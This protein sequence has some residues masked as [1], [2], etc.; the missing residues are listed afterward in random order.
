M[1][2]RPPRNLKVIGKT[3]D[4]VTLAWDPP[5]LDGGAAVF[6]HEVS[7]S[8]HKVVRKDKYSKDDVTTPAEP[9]LTSRWCAA[10]PVAANGFT[11]TELEANM[12]LVDISVRCQ[13]AVGWSDPSE[14]LPEVFT[15]DPVP[16]NP[17]LFFRVDLVKANRAVLRWMAPLFKGGVEVTEY[18]VA[19]VDVVPKDQQAVTTRKVEEDRHHEMRTPAIMGEE[20]KGEQVLVLR[21]LRAATLHKDISLRAIGES[22]MASAAVFAPVFTTLPPGQR[23]RIT[24]EL[25]RARAATGGWIDTDFYKDFMQARENREDYISKLERDLGSL[26]AGSADNEDSDEESASSQVRTIHSSQREPIP[27]RMVARTE[28]E[29]LRQQEDLL[30]SVFNGYKRRK[31]QF[32][33][34]LKRLREQIEECE[35]TRLAHIGHRAVL[36]QQLISTQ[37]RVMEIQAELDRV[38]TFKGGHINSSVLHGSQQRF[39]I[40]VL[41]QKLRIELGLGQSSIAQDKADLMEGTKTIAAF[42]VFTKN[43]EKAKKLSRNLQASKGDES[44][45]EKV[46][47]ALASAIKAIQ[48]ER[49]TILNALVRMRM[50]LIIAAFVKWRTGKHIAVDKP[51]DSTKYVIRGI[52]GRHLL[53][54]E[55]GRELM[56]KE[57]QVVMRDAATLRRGFTRMS[58][59]NSQKKELEGSSLFHETELGSFIDESEAAGLD[60]A[61]IAQGD[62][63]LKVRQAMKASACYSRQIDTLGMQSDRI[64]LSA[65]GL[66]H[67][68]LGKAQRAS[69][70]LDIAAVSFDRALELS[71]AGKHLPGVVDALEGL[72]GC[73]LEYCQYRDAISLFKRALARNVEIKDLPRDARLFRLLEEG[74]RRMVDMEQAAVYAQRAEAIE[75]ELEMKLSRAKTSLED[76]TTRL[77]GRTA[78][79]GKVVHLERV[80]AGYVAMCTRR[81]FLVENLKETLEAKKAQAKVLKVQEMKLLLIKEQLREAQET[82]KDAMSSTLIVEGEMMSFEIEELKTRLREREIEV[83]SEVTRHSGLLTA[84]TNRATNAVDELEGLEQDIAI[85][86][87]PLMTSVVGKARLRL[88]GMNS[89]NTAGNEVEGT[90]TGGVEKIIAAEGKKV[91]VYGI[92]RGNLEHVFSGDEP[93]R[94]TGELLGH[95][96]VI[97]ALFFHKNI[98]YTGSM[99]CTVQVWDVDEKKRVL[100]LKGHEATVCSVAADELKIVSGAADKNIHIWKHGDG[101]ILRVLHGHTKSAV[102]LHVG[103]S[104]ILSGG[105][106]GDIRLWG[107]GNS[108]KFTKASENRANVD[109]EE[110]LGRYECKRRLAGH[111][112]SAT[113]VSYGR[114]ELVSGHEDGTVVVWWASTGLI[115]MKS[116]VHGGPVQQLQFDATKVVSCSTDGTITVTDLTTGECTMTLRGH[117]GIVLAVAFDRS[118]IISASDDGTL[119]TWVWATRGPKQDK[120]AVLGPGENLGRLAKQNNT[121]VADIAKWNGVRDTRQLGVGVRLIVAKGNPNEPTEAETKAAEE[122]ALK[123]RRSKT[124]EKARKRVV[125]SGAAESGQQRLRGTL[126]ASDDPS[127]LIRRIARRDAS[128]ADMWQEARSDGDGGSGSQLDS[129]EEDD[130]SHDEER[131][132]EDVLA[133][134]AKERELAAGDVAGAVLGATVRLI[135]KEV[136]RD[137]IASAAPSKGIVGRLNAYCSLNAAVIPAENAHEAKEEQKE[138]KAKAPV[139]KAKYATRKDELGEP[140]VHLPPIEQTRVCTQ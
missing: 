19:Y 93:G 134:Q 17:P 128:F 44:V 109:D 65:L 91:L 57:L 112:R 86:G 12:H 98:V 67:A 55:E 70:R 48:Q 88:I 9:V 14:I 71:T 42:A 80:T 10:K 137:A 77:V 51:E 127:S 101:S 94:H 129:A 78:N 81:A 96:G 32:E 105:A 34:R 90:A 53:R 75:K 102:S 46:F 103:A 5:I 116:K 84:L 49:A 92:A 8:V 120:Y 100:V 106:D 89:S 24:D 20:D 38:A 15:E 13:N 140:G 22:G 113:C 3:C 138:N 79:K 37:A 60:T 33:C 11:L 108:S 124:I 27:D 54:A 99:D 97:T 6:E 56:E 1:A 121:T 87:G 117:E 131:D 52:G 16:P 83:S 130:E 31:A 28:Q 85:E 2:P 136:V 41:R 58:L 122:N 63:F 25:R 74:H 107:A 45:K 125:E 73:C 123:E 110:E 39:P 132:T 119:R 68:R 29:R 95:S 114:L 40:K 21:G 62:G 7:Y 72:G 135:A 82:D 18:D 30:E 115:M 66:A 64:G 126:A 133:K 35:E 111:Y 104:F 61:L 43:A 69:D 50:R 23:Q 76:S 4:Q 36:A 47:S 59:T 139:D 118:K 26:P